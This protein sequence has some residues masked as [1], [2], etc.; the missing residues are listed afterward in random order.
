MSDEDKAFK[1]QDQ[2]DKMI[3]RRKE[4]GKRR[5][6][7]KTG[8]RHR[9]TK[10][11]RYKPAVSHVVCDEWHIRKVFD[12][13]MVIPLCVVGAVVVGL[14]Q[15]KDHE[16][17]VCLVCVGTEGVEPRVQTGLQRDG[18]PVHQGVAVDTVPHQVVQ[19]ALIQAATERVQTSEHLR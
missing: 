6:P 3:E 10:W 16:A 7:G 2:Q 18:G 11:R 5:H 12:L 1:P 9:C 14:G 19:Y 17:L 15:V 8:L 13:E 4:K